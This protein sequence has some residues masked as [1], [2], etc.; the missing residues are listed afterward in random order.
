[1]GLARRY[2]PD[3]LNA[4]CERALRSATLRYRSVKSILEHG[5][6]RVDAESATRL[7]LPPTHAHLRG[8]TYYATL[9]PTAGVH[10]ALPTNA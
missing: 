5:L 4:A 7:A 9:T 8:A 6:D 2:G 3:R 1:M 10:D